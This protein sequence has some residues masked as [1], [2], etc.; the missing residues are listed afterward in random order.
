MF[1]FHVV[2]SCLWSSMNLSKIYVFNLHA[3]NIYLPLLVS[4][5]VHLNMNTISDRVSTSSNHVIR[6]LH[7]DSLE[8][9]MAA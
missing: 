2:A 4:L 7:K 3:I 8:L 5:F 6:S 1:P 9:L